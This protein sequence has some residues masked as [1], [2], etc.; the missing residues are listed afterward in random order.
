[1]VTSWYFD[2]P[3]QRAYT[4]LP[5]KKETSKT[6]DGICLIHFLAFRVPCRPNH[7][8]NHQNS[9]WSAETKNQASE[10]DIFRVLSSLYSFNLCG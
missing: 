4:G 1:M 2:C 5:T 7:L 3:L 10:R 9:Q 8:V 6:T